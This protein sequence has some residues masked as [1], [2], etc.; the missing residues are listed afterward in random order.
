LIPL[1]ELE[2]IPLPEFPLEPL[3]LLCFEPESNA[4][5]EAAQ[6]KKIARKAHHQKRLPEKRIE[7]PRRL[8]PIGGNLTPL[9]DD[10]GLPYGLRQCRKADLVSARPL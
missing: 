3:P 10:I 4:R 7:V 2:L 8:R 9:S 1:P 5:P 6:I